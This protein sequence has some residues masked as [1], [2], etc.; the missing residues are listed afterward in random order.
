MLNAASVTI[1]DRDP[2]ANAEVVLQQDEEA[3]DDVS[4]QALGAEA[5]GQP[6]HAGTRQEWR[7]VGE[8]AEDHQSRDT[9]QQH[10]PGGLTNAD[11]RVKPHLALAGAVLRALAQA[12]GE[13]SERRPPYA[14]TNGSENDD[15]SAGE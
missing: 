5:D 8:L 2:I 14:E 1:V 6:D 3:G 9:R 4:N 12:V 15:D 7:D 10:N 13:P 11:Q